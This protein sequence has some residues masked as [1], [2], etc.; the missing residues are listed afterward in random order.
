MSFSISRAIKEEVLK[1]SLSSTSVP[2]SKARPKCKPLRREDA[3][4]VLPP[5]G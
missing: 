3:Y 5:L 1:L 2:P 4:M